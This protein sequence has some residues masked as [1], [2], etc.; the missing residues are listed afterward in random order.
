MVSGRGNELVKAMV[1]TKR[2]ERGM[3]RGERGR[4]ERLIKD[5]EIGKERTGARQIK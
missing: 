2:K 5:M 3:K 1:V 4:K